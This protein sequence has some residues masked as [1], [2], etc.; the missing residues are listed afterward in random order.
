[1]NTWKEECVLLLKNLGGHAYLKDI[2]AEFVKHGTRPKTQ[3]YDA[4]IRAALEKGSKE[5]SYFDGEELFYMVDGKNKGHYGLVDYIS[6]TI[7]LTQEDDEFSE[8]KLML[9][10]I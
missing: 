7:D 4:S 2:Y 1:M 9:K 3:S 5:S 6:E 10:N 8:G